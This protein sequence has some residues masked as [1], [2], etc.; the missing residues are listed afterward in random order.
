MRLFK[1]SSPAD[2]LDN[3]LAA[4]WAWWAGAKDGIARDIP[5]RQVARRTGEISQAVAG[6]DKRL[7]W[8]L[9]Q[10]QSS[11]HMLIVTPEGNAEVRPIAL[12]WL[13]SAPPADGTWEY[14]ASRQPG[15]PRTLQ[16]AG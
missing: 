11:Q 3:R 1:R 2:D 12:A 16:V 14:R 8:E 10:G 4:F 7:A 6:I 13:S 9:S 15:E 5:A